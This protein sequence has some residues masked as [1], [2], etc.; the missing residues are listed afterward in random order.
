MD[1]A[2][3][4]CGF[5][6]RSEQGN[7]DV[8]FSHLSCTYRYLHRCKGEYGSRGTPWAISVGVIRCAIANEKAMLIR[9]MKSYH[10]PSL[11]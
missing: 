3:R 11:I 5:L 8:S 7:E 4:M 1:G 10:P 6:E 9:M 2:G